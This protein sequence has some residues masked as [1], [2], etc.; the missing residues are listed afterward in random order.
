MKTAFM[1]HFWF[2]ANQALRGI[3]CNCHSRETGKDAVCGPSFKYAIRKPCSFGAVSQISEL[4]KAK[5]RKKTGNDLVLVEFIFLPMGCCSL[6]SLS[7]DM[8]TLILNRPCAIAGS[9]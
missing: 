7:C 2:V 8:P 5:I 4:S 9:S 1:W 6:L 3:S